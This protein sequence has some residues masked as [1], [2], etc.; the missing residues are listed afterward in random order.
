MNRFS[1]R[2][3]IPCLMAMMPAAMVMAAD[4]PKV[5][6]YTEEI[7][8]TVVK[9]NM[10]K[11]PAGSVEIKV[12]DQ[13]KKV[14]LKPFAISETE[15]TWDEFDT[16]AYGLDIADEK[17]KI[18]SI[19]KT[20]PSKPYGAPDFGFGHS[21]YPVLAET[22]FSAEMYCKWLSEKTG[23]KFRLPTEAEW[24]YACRAG[25]APVKLEK[26][27]L[28][29]VAWFEENGDE[30]TH[31]VK[32]KAAN[33]FGLYDTLGNAVEWVIKDPDWQKLDEADDA[34]NPDRRMKKAKTQV[35]RGGSWKEAGEKINSS[36]RFYQL[37]SWNVT[38]PQDPKSRWWLSDGK[39]VSFRVVCED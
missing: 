3:M 34:A 22:Y 26:E 25:G 24:E 36:Q 13:T 23:K 6:K 33:A 2:L 37:P 14:D 7:K 39:F 5:E 9:F 28:E 29:K 32:E 19:S 10:V 1:L 12:G 18:E 21:G 4:A 38:D 16:W 15:V 20:R 31:P 8:G 35:A 30:K 11:L 17:A 27:E